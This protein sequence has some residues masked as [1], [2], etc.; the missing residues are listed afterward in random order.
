MTKCDKSDGKT[1][2]EIAINTRSTDASQKNTNGNGNPKE[3]KPMHWLSTSRSVLT[4]ITAQIKVAKTLINPKLTRLFFRVETKRARVRRKRK[5]SLKPIRTPIKNVLHM[6]KRS[7]TT[8]HSVPVTMMTRTALQDE[9]ERAKVFLQDFHSRSSLSNEETEAERT[10]PKNETVSCL[11]DMVDET[12]EPPSG[13]QQ[14]QEEEVLASSKEDT[15]GWGHFAYAPQVVVVK[16]HH[17]N[18]P[19][20]PRYFPRHHRSFK[21]VYR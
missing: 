16:R 11:R 14:Q 7:R 18:L 10:I 20:R 19:P 21:T 6:K 1:V 4:D 17:R 8:Q 5:T 13:T 3:K 12:E 2:S 9:Y 15:T